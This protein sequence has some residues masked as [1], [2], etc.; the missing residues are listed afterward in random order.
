[1][2]HYFDIASVVRMGEVPIGTGAKQGKG[3]FLYIL[4][5]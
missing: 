1:M 2:F 5:N 4:N 3:S